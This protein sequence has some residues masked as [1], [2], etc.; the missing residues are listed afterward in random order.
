M[1]VAPFWWPGKGHSAAQRRCHHPHGEGGGHLVRVLMNAGAH[2][3]QKFSPGAGSPAGIRQQLGPSGAWRGDGAGAWFARLSW[4]SG[5]RTCVGSAPSRLGLS[6]ES[7]QALLVSRKFTT[8]RS[9][10]GVPFHCFFF[11]FKNKNRRKKVRLE[12][13]LTPGCS[14][15]PRTCRHRVTRVN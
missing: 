13:W 15:E 14:A 5:R 8:W 2:G 1:A 3:G 10:R 7:L 4:K 12:R 6:T 11:V 9:L